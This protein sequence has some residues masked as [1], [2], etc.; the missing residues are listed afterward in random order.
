MYSGSRSLKKDLME[1]QC[2]VGQGHFCV[3]VIGQYILGHG[4]FVYI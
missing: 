3:H 4:Y 2:I 1:G